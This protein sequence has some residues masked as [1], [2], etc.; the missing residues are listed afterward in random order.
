MAG[1]LILYGVPLLHP[2]PIRAAECLA[3]LAAHRRILRSVAPWDRR[4]RSDQ[5]T[6]EKVS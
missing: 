3:A 5:M 6:F 1:I 4:R 2:S